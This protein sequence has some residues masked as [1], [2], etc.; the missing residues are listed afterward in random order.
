MHSSVA[1]QTA[2]NRV[3]TVKSIVRVLQD[4]GYELEALIPPAYLQ[5]DTE[6]IAAYAY[7]KILDGVRFATIINN[8]KAWEWVLTTRG[9]PGFE[10]L[11]A[12]QVL[13]NTTLAG[14]DAE[15]VKATPMTLTLISSVG[16]R[17]LA[18]HKANPQGSSKSFLALRDYVALHMSFFGLLRRSDA[19]N[20]TVGGI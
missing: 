10:H 6:A 20:I 9:H 17:L 15:P 16:K 12:V 18:E 3:R 8:L 11:K 19:A 13:F 4:K 1:R 5:V 14:K 2:S 7:I